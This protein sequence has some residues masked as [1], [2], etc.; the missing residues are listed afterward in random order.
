MTIRAA[1]LT[2]SALIALSAAACSPSGGANQTAQAP[3]AKPAP[4]KVA[5]QAEAADP[6]I[7]QRVDAINKALY[8]AP[9]PDAAPSPANTTAATSNTT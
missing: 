6:A 3:P 5:A 7:Q 9:S 4:V 2:A 1:S 8:A